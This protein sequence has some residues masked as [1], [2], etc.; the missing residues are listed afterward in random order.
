MQL[1]IDFDKESTDSTI[2]DLT[3]RDMV[4]KANTTLK[5]MNINDPDK[6]QTVQF[7]TARCIQNNQILYQFNSASATEWIRKPATH[8]AFLMAYSS[9]TKICNKLYHTITE[10]VPTTFNMDDNYSHN[11]LEITNSLKPGSIAWS[12]YIKLPNLCSANQ[13]VAHVILS[14]SSKNT[15]NK[16][17]QHGLYIEGKHITV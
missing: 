10:F 7:M 13:K 16:V 6:L 4:A 1:L 3:E 8:K 15:A 12:R 2:A 5:I 17:I 11:K 9:S 14:L